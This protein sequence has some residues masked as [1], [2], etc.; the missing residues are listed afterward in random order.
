MSDAKFVI[1]TLSH[2]PYCQKAKQLLKENNFYFTEI[3]V[4]DDDQKARDALS[5]Q[6][7]LKTFPQIFFG[8]QLVGGYSNL[9]QI[10]DE[11]GLQQ[12]RCHTNVK[13]NAS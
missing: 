5:N 13:E 3:P 8:P 1:Y 12:F 7:G 2:C 9:K 4:A 11:N 6:S 10:F